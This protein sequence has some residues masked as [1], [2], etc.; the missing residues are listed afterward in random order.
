M[1]DDAS[2]VNTVEGDNKLKVQFKSLKFIEPAQV[3]GS[4]DDLVGM[5]D[6]KAEVEHPTPAYDTDVDEA[7]KSEG[8]SDVSIED[9]PIALAL[10]PPG[11]L[12]LTHRR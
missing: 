6:I 12:M 8:D 2:R 9:V 5:D 10:S 3:L 7:V 11:G 4:I 1:P